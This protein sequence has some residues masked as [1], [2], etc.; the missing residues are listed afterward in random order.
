MTQ[1]TRVH[2][3]ASSLELLSRSPT[4]EFIDRSWLHLGDPPNYEARSYT[5][6]LKSKARAFAK[7][8]LRRGG[9]AKEGDPALYD[10]TD[11]RAWIFKPGDRLP[12]EDNSVGFI[13]SEHVL[14]H[15]RFDLGADLL[16]ECR[17]VLKPGGVIRTVVPDADYRTYEKPE[18][19]GYPSPALG[20]SH[21][22]KHK[23]R[24]NN[25]L[26]A[27]TLGFIGF[28]PKSL[29]W[30]DEDGTFVQTDPKDA[31]AGRATADPDM[32]GTLRYVQ[33]PRSLIVD[34]FKPA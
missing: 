15:F 6:T 27:K 19:A 13:Y 14:E 26:L 34:G 7:R 18:I 28:E 10:K 12:L 17:R 4:A 8:V 30:C 2:L 25:Y 5:G 21:P 24:W 22:N 16:A 20:F 11:F 33:R 32:V 29:A 1:A 9:V 23:V 31:Y 3:G